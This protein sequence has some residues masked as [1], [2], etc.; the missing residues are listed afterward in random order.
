MYY[1]DDYQI[2][3]E[4]AR[5]PVNHMVHSESIQTEEGM[6]LEVLHDEV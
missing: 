1:P 5:D 6:Q 2:V 4:M 3:Q